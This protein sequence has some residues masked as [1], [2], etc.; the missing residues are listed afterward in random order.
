MNQ[1]YEKT[2]NRAMILSVTCV[3][4]IAIVTFLDGSVLLE[5]LS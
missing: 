5:K 1:Q 3:R 4:G 2:R